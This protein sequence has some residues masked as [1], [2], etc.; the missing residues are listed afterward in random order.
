MYVTIEKLKHLGIEICGGQSGHLVVSL[1]V[2]VGA[3]V[4]KTIQ[5]DRLYRTAG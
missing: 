5:Q 1:A 2:V 3:Y 4:A